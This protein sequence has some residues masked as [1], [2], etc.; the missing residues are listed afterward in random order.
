MLSIWL[1]RLHPCK[2]IL[3]SFHVMLFRFDVAKTSACYKTSQLR[4]M[5]YPN[6]NLLIRSYYMGY[7]F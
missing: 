7:S 1:S 4:L 3:V 6:L 5:I 2:Y